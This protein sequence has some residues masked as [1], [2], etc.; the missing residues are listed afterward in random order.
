[1]E[2]FNGLDH[3][4]REQEPLAP[5]GWLRTGAIARYFAEPTTADELV[6]LVSLCKSRDLSV[7][8][9]G[10]GSN[11]L[12]ASE[13][14]DAMIVHLS[15]AAFTEITVEGNC[16]TAR[17]GA[18]LVQ[19]LSTAAREGLSG[20]ESLAGIPGTVAGALKT[21]AGTH[22]DDIGQWTR[23]VKVL[24]RDGEVLVREGDQ[25]RFSYRESSLN[26]LVILENTPSMC[27]FNLVQHNVDPRLHPFVKNGFGSN[28]VLVQWS[29][30]VLNVPRYLQEHA[31]YSPHHST[32]NKIDETL[33]KCSHM[34]IEVHF[35]RDKNEWLI[36]FVVGVIQ[37]RMVCGTCPK[38]HGT[39]KLNTYSTRF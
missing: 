25:L 30:T 22:N 11:I 27:G 37:C 17:G 26:E 7:K 29:S 28:Y 6:A 20:L 32:S 18:K 35:E 34:R 9:L 4:V 2:D 38:E 31:P 36:V 15:A 5:Y 13:I 12:V 16:I 39:F 24:T 14:V 10:G 23:A 19:L 3:I 1:M 8:L 21:N 33:R